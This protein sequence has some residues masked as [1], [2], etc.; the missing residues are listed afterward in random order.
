MLQQDRQISC[1][2]VCNSL[3]SGRIAMAAAASGRD[4]TICPS[5]VEVRGCMYTYTSTYAYL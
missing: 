2:I 4:C 5:A 1:P 3:Q